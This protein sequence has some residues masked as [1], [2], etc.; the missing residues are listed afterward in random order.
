MSIN[1]GCNELG[2]I[3]FESGVAENAVSGHI[4]VKLKS[5]LIMI[6]FYN[7]FPK[8]LSVIFRAPEL[9]VYHEYVNV[10]QL[11]TKFQK[12]KNWYIR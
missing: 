9:I 3:W 5:S 1:Q 4:Q 11:F 6:W 12:P 10:A 7:K 2:Q 8:I